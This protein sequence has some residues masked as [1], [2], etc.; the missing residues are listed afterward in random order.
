MSAGLTFERRLFHMLF[1]TVRTLRS[2]GRRASR[3]S[4][5]SELT[6][7]LCG[8]VVTMTTTG[9]SEG[10][11][12]RVCREE[13][14]K[15]HAQV[16]E[17]ATEDVGQRAAILSRPSLIAGIQA[18]SCPT[19]SH[20]TRG[21]VTC[22]CLWHECNIFRDTLLYAR[23]QGLRRRG[24]NGRAGSHRPGLTCL[25]TTSPSFVQR[26]TLHLAVSWLH[27]TST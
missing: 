2:S 22:E 5:S 16:D 1:A 11:D 8:G 20:V 17:P 21:K 13:E 3:T 10:R 23:G 25:C 6:S 19:R 18:G 4:F 26:A 14:G 12:G 15:L 7:L 9:R 27:H 24:G